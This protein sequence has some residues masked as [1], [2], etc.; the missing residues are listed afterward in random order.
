MTFLCTWWDSLLWSIKRRILFDSVANSGIQTANGICGLRHARKGLH[1]GI[2]RLSMGTFG[3]WFT[4]SVIVGE[5][6]ATILVFLVRDF[7][8]KLPVCQKRSES[9]R[10]QHREF[11]Y[12]WLQ[13]PNRRQYHLE[14]STAKGNFVQDKEAE[15][16]IC[17]KT[18]FRRIGSTRCIFLNS[19]IWRWP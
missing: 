7:H 3:G 9:D 10:W 12:P 13:L 4:V 6:Y 17:L 16:W 8:E 15:C 11:S 2:W 5:D 14:F 18:I 19:D 1:Q